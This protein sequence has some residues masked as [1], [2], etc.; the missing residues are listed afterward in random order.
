MS[1]I[2]CQRAA[3][4]IEDKAH[5]AYDVSSYLAPGW[6]EVPDRCYINIRNKSIIEI[7]KRKGLMKW[8]TDVLSGGCVFVGGYDPAEREMFG[9]APTIN[10]EAMIE[11]IKAC[12]GEVTG[13]HDERLLTGKE[14]G[15]PLSKIAHVHFI[16]DPRSAQCLIRKL[17]EEP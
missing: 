3:R 9:E 12:S 15:G 1:I 2:R 13:V 8:E 17:L 7:A 5:P 11:R 4:K 10:K 6:D 16:A 14:R